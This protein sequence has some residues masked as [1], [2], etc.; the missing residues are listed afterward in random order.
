VVTKCFEL[1]ESDMFEPKGGCEQKI[2]G[3]VGCLDLSL[4][5]WTF[6]I[7]SSPI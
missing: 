6:L 4:F 5:V 2:A 3:L 7:S 1:E